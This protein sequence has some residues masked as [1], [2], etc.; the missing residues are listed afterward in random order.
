MQIA[1]EVVTPRKAE[2]WLNENKS[3]RKLREGVAEKYALDM[4]AGRWTTCPTPISFYED[5]DLA[6]GQHR[7]FA[8]IESGC[9]V[10]L[11]IARGLKR[12]DGLNID[13]GLGRSLVDNA[14]IS[15]AD[16]GLSNELLG[17]TRAVATGSYAQGSPSS[18]E[19][20]A[21]VESHREACQWAMAN[22]PKGKFLRNA[23]VL[24]AVARAW[25]SE[26]DT[27]RLHRFCDV[28]SSGFS[29]GEHESAAIALRNYLLQRAAES[30]RNAVW[31]DT[32]LKVQNAI[33]YFMRSRKLTVIKT[34]S[35]E[36]YPLP[37]QKKA[38]AA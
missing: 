11:P 1:I 24:G 26:A 13:T 20:L 27:D 35:E 5:G 21:W 10:N 38:R 19:R 28:L 31:R 29:N 15:G 25:Y 36:L 4:K 12:E 2:Q 23:V 16:R 30:S 3:N 14:R 32:F 8:I 22:G 17:V 33:G 9:S 7:L 6:D 34:V 18:A 37:K